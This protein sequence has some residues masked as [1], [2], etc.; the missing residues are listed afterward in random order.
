MV[1]IYGG[2]YLT[3]SDRA[4]AGY[5]HQCWVSFAKA[6]VPACPGGP[7]WRPYSATDN[8]IM[9]LKDTRAVATGFRKVQLDWHNHYLADRLARFVPG[10]TMPTK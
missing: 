4:V 7:T 8:A 9:L 2:A 6:G 10:P 3:A 1:W 5:V